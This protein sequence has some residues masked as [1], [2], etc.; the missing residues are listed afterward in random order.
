MVL[1]PRFAYYWNLLFKHKFPQFTTTNKISSLEVDSKYE[2]N[3]YY[4]HWLACDKEQLFL[5]T[6]ERL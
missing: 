2:Y 5:G 1:T 3:R 6:N 4:F